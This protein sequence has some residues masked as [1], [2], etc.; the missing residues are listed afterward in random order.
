MIFI[1]SDAESMKIYNVVIENVSELP[2]PNSNSNT[3]IGEL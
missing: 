2:V 3:L 1:I